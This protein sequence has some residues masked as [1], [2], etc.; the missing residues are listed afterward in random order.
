MIFT[1][2]KS[3]AMAVTNPIVPYK[4]PSEQ[5][6]PISDMIMAQAQYSTAGW[7]GRIVT[8][9]PLGP[10]YWAKA[11]IRPAPVFSA[12]SNHRIPKA[13]ASLPHTHPAG[14]IWGW[15]AVQDRMSPEK[16]CSMSQS[17]PGPITDKSSS[18]SLSSTL[19]HL[20]L[21]DSGGS[22]WDRTLEAQPGWAGDP[23]HSSVGWRAAWRQHRIESQTTH[24]PSCG[25]RYGG[26][27]K[28]GLFHPIEDIPGTTA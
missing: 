12:H 7:F 4:E 27:I 1:A 21:I 22:L 15:P 24:N 23:S 5:C 9:V 11:G 10:G 16:L 28:T 14:L 3:V 25:S 26:H 2:Q 13:G 18:A 6:Y 17:S 8:L 20:G 19:G